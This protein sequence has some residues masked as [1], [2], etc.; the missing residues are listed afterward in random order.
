M[1]SSARYAV[2]APPLRMEAGVRPR[3][4]GTPKAA[5]MASQRRRKDDGDPAYRGSPACSPLKTLSNAAT[6]DAEVTLACCTTPRPLRRLFGRRMQRKQTSGC[7]YTRS[8]G[9][10][11]SNLV[12]PRGSPAAK[13][14]HSQVERADHLPQGPSAGMPRFSTKSSV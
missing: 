8:L 13:E 1:S 4:F 14:T 5:R 11:R 3:V 6:T 9:S 2:I 10:R 12:A 7:S